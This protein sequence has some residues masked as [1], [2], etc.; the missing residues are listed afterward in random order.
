M[1]IVIGEMLIDIFP[2]YRRIGGAPFNFAFHLKK[3]G[4]P[5]RLISRVGDDQNGEAIL[6]MASRNGFDTA[7]IQIDAKNPT[8][9]VQVTLDNA[10]VPRFDIRRNVAYDHLELGP[11]ILTGVDDAT[12][13]YYGSLL[14]RTDAGHRQVVDFLTRL[15]E[16]TVRFCDINLRPPHVNHHAVADSLRHAD[17]LKLNDDELVAIR[18]NVGG[19]ADGDAMMPWLLETF[20]LKGMVLTRGAHGSS[21]AGPDGIIHSPVANAG[22]IVDTVGAGD[23][24]AAI[25]AAGYLRRL[26]WETSMVLASRFG[27]RICSIPG[28]IPGDDAFYDDFRH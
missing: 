27:A 7:D 3:L 22:T 15:G 17:L 24:F 10:G 26:D 20:D 28:A 12:L 21:F 13:I 16:G 8:G 6:S 9:T 1:I 14:Q 18:R 11:D 4:F 23:G 5:V 2:E 19:P 25:L